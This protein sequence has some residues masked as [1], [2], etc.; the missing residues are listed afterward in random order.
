MN[1]HVPL[2]AGFPNRALFEV[3]VI[4]H[5]HWMDTIIETP[6]E[7]GSLKEPNHSGQEIKLHNQIAVERTSNNT[8]SLP[9]S[10]LFMLQQLQVSFAEGE[11]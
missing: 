2:G 5:R 9:V 10:K 3:G 8:F 1:T 7:K 4:L 11:R 6:H